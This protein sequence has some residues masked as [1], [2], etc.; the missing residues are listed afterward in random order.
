MFFEAK[1]H[2]VV[3]YIVIYLRV[4]TITCLYNGMLF[5]LATPPPLLASA[6]IQRS[7]NDSNY[8]PADIANVEVQFPTNTPEMMSKSPAQ[9]LKVGQALLARRRTHLDN[10]L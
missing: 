6:S 7:S 10:K 5:A 2:N 4:V 3:D 8:S 1:K 9:Q